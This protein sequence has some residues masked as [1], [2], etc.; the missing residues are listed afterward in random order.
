[1]GPGRE[2]RSMAEEKNTALTESQLNQ[3]FNAFDKDGSGELDFIE[4][5]MFVKE[6]KKMGKENVEIG[7]ILEK[8]DKN[9]DK[10]VDFTEFKARMTE[11]LVEYPEGKDILTCAAL[12]KYNQAH[13][14]NR[15]EKSVLPWALGGA[16]L[17]AVAAFTFMKFK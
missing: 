3:I 15:A 8:W 17:V 9:G 7:K 6:L 4:M 16:A 5:T 13:V 11:Y 2:N 14:A 1:M 12:K 10:A